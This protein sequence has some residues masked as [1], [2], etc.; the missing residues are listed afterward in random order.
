MA[1]QHWVS[2]LNKKPKSSVPHGTCPLKLGICIAQTSLWSLDSGAF[3]ECAMV[4]RR[5]SAKKGLAIFLCKVAFFCISL[6]LSSPSP[7]SPATLRSSYSTD[8]PKLV[9]NLPMWVI[10]LRESFT[11]RPQGLFCVWSKRLTLSRIWNWYQWYIEN[12]Q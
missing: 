8:F 7:F 1:V 12:I 10:A 9:E 3:L 6:Y 11:L 2:D 5:S 4:I